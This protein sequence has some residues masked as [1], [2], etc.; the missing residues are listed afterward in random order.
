VSRTVHIMHKLKS[1][2]LSWPSIVDLK[3]DWNGHF[4]NETSLTKYRNNH[5]NLMFLDWV[6]W[7]I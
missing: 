6:G 5:L 4:R 2:M 3:C 1:L 7:C